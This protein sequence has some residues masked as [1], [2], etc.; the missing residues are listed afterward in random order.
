[1]LNKKANPSTVV[2][3]TPVHVSEMITGNPNNMVK[4]RSP[5]WAGMEN[6]NFERPF[7]H[8]VV[9][10]QWDIPLG[11]KKSDF[12]RIASP[13]PRPDSPTPLKRI[14]A[15]DLPPVTLSPSSFDMPL[16]RD[17]L[18]VDIPDAVTKT[19]ETNFDPRF[20]TKRPVARVSGTLYHGTGST[21]PKIVHGIPNFLETSS[22]KNKKLTK[23]ATKGKR[24]TTTTKSKAKTATKSK[25]KTAT[26]SKAKTATKSKTKTATKSKAK[27]ATKTKTKTVSK[28]RAK[29]ITLKMLKSMSEDV[30]ECM[31]IK[32]QATN[33]KQEGFDIANGVE[34]RAEDDMNQVVPDPSEKHMI[35]DVKTDNREE[36]P[37]LM[38]HGDNYAEA[39]RIKQLE[40]TS[41][42]VYA[43]HTYR[44]LPP[45]KSRN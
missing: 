28:N 27:T 37:S 45:M 42:G 33:L 8:G 6:P 15:N 21:N 20:P 35:L 25:A 1:M 16:R 18:Q 24:A 5:I 38:V 30:D 13:M 41:A 4:D 40:R 17:V 12:N 26:K 9:G 10:P 14:I 7:M 34:Y 39:R 32:D 23:K 3:T 44:T 19:T 36:E 11:T 22:K 43:R 2:N 31:D 29:R